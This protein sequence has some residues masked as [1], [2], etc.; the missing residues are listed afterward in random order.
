MHIQISMIVYAFIRYISC[1]HIPSVI[2]ILD[3][4]LY[5]K[6]GTWVHLRPKSD[7]LR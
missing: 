1:M 5:L 3:G 7:T 6:A 2:N 4:V